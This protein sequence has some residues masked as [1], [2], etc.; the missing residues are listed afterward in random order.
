VARKTP[1]TSLKQIS[2]INLTPLM[3]LTFI[4]LIT[5]IITFPLIEQ[6]IAVNLPRG[7]AA[8][9]SDEEARTVTVDAEGAI[10]LDNSPVTLEELTDVMMTLAGTT[11][12]VTVMVRANEAIEYGTVVDV[13]KVLNKARIGKMALVTQ[14]E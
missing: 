4:L 12:D 3:D 6:G 7:K 5:F 1:R 11:P 8:E 2:E 13:L 9:L 10:Y 14:E